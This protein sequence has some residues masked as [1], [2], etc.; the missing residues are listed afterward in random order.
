MS[1]GREKKVFILRAACVAGLIVLLAG[2]SAR[3]AIVSVE[4][5]GQV[6]YVDDRDEVLGGQIQANDIFVGS[7][8]YD[9][10]LPDSNPL[11]GVG[12]Y[13]HLSSPFGITLNIN[14]LLFASNPQDVHCLIELYNDYGSTDRYMI[15]STSNLPVDGVEVGQILW[16]L[17]DS[18][19]TALNSDALLMTAPVLSDWQSNNFRI[20]CG[21]DGATRIGGTITDA[22]T[23]YVVPEPTT[24]IL[25]GFG[26]VVLCR[27]RA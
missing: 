18:N 19:C 13:E 25:M 2:R 1:F 5:I 15:S 8:S 7:Y 27:R 20:T 6:T 12:E 23:V 9:P 26:A 16:Q 24:V 14:G 3:G 10:F 11:A 22:Y 4:I 17:N 21:N